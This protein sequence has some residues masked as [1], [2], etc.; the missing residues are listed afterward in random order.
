MNSQEIF[1]KVLNGLGLQGH[2]CVDLGGNC[3]YRQDQDKCAVGIL[4]PDDDYT[5]GIEGSTVFGIIS[6]NKGE[7][8]GV[9]QEKRLQNILVKIGINVADYPLLAELQ[10]AHDDILKRRGRKAWEAK[11]NTIAERYS[12]IYTS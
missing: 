9:H 4:I 7:R 2:A 6:I 1:D 11:M 5:V 12:L 3:V 8:D 10:Q